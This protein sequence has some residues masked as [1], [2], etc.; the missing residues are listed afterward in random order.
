M[1][2]I[3]GAFA[4]LILCI[5]AAT[6]QENAPLPPGAQPYGLVPVQNAQ[7]DAMPYGVKPIPGYTPPA[8]MAQPAPAPEMLRGSMRDAPASP[9]GDYGYVPLRQAEPLQPPL[10]A[11][12]STDDQGD[13]AY[14]PQPNARQQIAYQ[15]APVRGSGDYRLGAGDKV[16]VTVFGESDLSGEY[17]IDGSGMVRLPLIGTLQATGA[18]APALEQNIAAALEQG[19]IKAPRVNVEITLYRPFYIIGAVNRPGQYPYVDHM[20]ALNAVALAGGFTDQAIQSTIYV[21][22]EGSAT[23]QSVETSQLTHI[24]PGDVVRVRTSPF[25]EAINLFSPV[26][27]P[28]AI[29]AAAWH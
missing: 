7:P 16:R 26:A 17:Q 12:S 23:E 14:L 27:G 25:W 4:L 24:E 6:A 3:A 29:A 21:R 1:S 11:S 19:Y 22:H 2:M 10:R 9:Q 5:R 8:P 15:P 28:A 18:T 13:T 20:S